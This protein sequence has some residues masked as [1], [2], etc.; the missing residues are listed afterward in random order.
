MYDLIQSHRQATK[1]ELSYLSSGSVQM[2]WL[3]FDVLLRLVSLMQLELSQWS[4]FKGEN[5][6]W[7]FLEQFNIG[8]YMGIYRPIYFECGTM[9]NTAKH[10]LIMHWYQFEWPEPLAKTTVAGESQHFCVLFSLQIPQIYL[11]EI[12]MLPQPFRLLKLMLKLFDM[13]AIKW[14]NSVLM[15]SWNTPCHWHAF[16]HILFF[17]FFFLKLVQC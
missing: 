4:I 14:G 6:W 10:K 15:I 16:W 13:I 7:Y 1:R 9:M 3:E 8:L 5:I 2:M 12:C 17:F 11:I